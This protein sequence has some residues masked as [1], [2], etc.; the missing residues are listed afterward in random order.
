[1]KL[2]KLA[3][4][5]MLLSFLF[6][7]ISPVLAL[8]NKEKKL[9]AEKKQHLEYIN[10]AWWENFG[11]DYLTDY[12]LRA[13]VN[14]SDAKIATLKVEETRQK[15]KLQFSNEF[16]VLYIG[17]SPSL[18][19]LPGAEDSQKYF[20]MPAIAS[21]EFD[22]F[23][24]NRD[25]TRSVKKMYEAS[26]LSEK[27]A[28]ISVAS[29]VGTT[30]YNLVK[31]D[32]LIDLQKQIV[33]LRKRIYE[34]KQLSYNQG[35]VSMSDLIIA[36]KQFVNSEIA[37]SDLQKA[38]MTILTA[39]AVLIGDTPANINKYEHIS[40]ADLKLTK[41][42]PEEI[43]SDVIMNRPDY[44]IAEK[45]LEKAGIDVRI[46]K[47]EF[48]PTFNIVGFM[49]FLSSAEGMNFNYQN[50][51][52]A[53][54]LSTL[55]P[56]FT[57]GKRIANFKLNKNQ[58]LQAM[59]NYQ[60]TNLAS[61]KEVDDALTNLKFD[62]DKYQKTKKTFDIEEKN[63]KLCELKFKQG[64]ISQLNLLEKEEALLYTKRL[65]VSNDID[66]FINHISLYKATAAK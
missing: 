4:I 27:A 10:L 1:M 29:A 15:M 26:K 34:L 7:N 56:I 32:E 18:A 58:Y 33:A 20:A 21:Y 36:E 63:Y 51:L 23:L 65:L 55:Y 5:T 61:I 40:Y 46:A 22:I 19:K 14:N 45:M 39:L 12:I 31:T 38:R 54:A 24:K 37:L 50:A 11:D 62:Y 42:I 59:E 30:Y 17:A 52:G 9:E 16:P 44:L 53:L 8:G 13:M 43:P 57:G 49:A 28:Y 6:L 48:L 41:K 60:K 66:N 64:T 25:K 35:I 47:K 2:K 3:I